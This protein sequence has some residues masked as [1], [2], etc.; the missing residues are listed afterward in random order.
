MLTLRLIE[1]NGYSVPDGLRTVTTDGE[2]QARQD[3]KQLAT[4]HA[5]QWADFGY[6][7]NDYRILTDPAT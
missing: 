6:H 2:S 4:E 7:P 5:A 1:P 3:L